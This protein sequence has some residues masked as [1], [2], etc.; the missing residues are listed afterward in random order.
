[1]VGNRA[2]RCSLN[3]HEPLPTT[4]DWANIDHRRGIS[5]APGEMDDW[6]GAAQN[7]PSDL[8]V[9]IES[10]H[11]LNDRGAV[12]THVAHEVSHDG[13]LAEWRVINVQT[14]HGDLIDRLEMF[15]E[16]DV[17]A[18][19]ERFEQLTRPRPQLENAASRVNK[20]LQEWFAARDWAAIAQE[21]SD[22]VS[23]DDR[24]RVV[25]MGLRQGRNALMAEAR[26]LV[27]IGIQRNLRCHRCPRTRLVFSRVR[28]W[29]RDQRP[30]A[31]HTDA[32]EIIEIDVDDRIVAR[33]VFDLDDSMPPSPNWKF[34]TSPG[35]RPRTSIWS[36]VDRGFRGT[37]P[38][39]NPCDDA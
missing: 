23:H 15:D 3:R 32:L 38:T 16:T 11:C 21:L 19:I 39:E 13:S 7:R 24:R 33:V 27:E 5:I 10:V 8:S 14:V 29:G 30:D 20:R 28:T 12:V 1:M 9:F 6:I 34:G 37:E 18:A 25:G 2:K 31:F 36:L 35:R 22:N 17:D 26:A 4:P